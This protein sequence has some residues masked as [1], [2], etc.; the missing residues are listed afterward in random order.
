VGDLGATIKEILANYDKY[1]FLKAEYPFT[2]QFYGALQAM[3]DSLAR[4]DSR[5]NQLVQDE[6]AR[7]TTIHR[8]T[9]F[10][11][12]R[13]ALNRIARSPAAVGFLRE[14]IAQLSAPYTDSVTF[15]PVQDRPELEVYRGISSVAKELPADVRGREVTYLTVGSLN[16]DYRSAVLDGE[17][18][19]VLSGDWSLIGWPDFFAEWGYVTWVSSPEEL[20]PYMPPGSNTQ[21]WLGRRLRRII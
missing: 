11:G 9:Q 7:A 2:L 3:A 5:S 16:K 6:V 21:R 12:T 20:E 1:P 17:T 15:R 18:V 14:Y 8:K 10:F 19:Y 4:V 13:A